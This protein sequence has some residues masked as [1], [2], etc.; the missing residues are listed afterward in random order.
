MTLD[1]Q[2]C[3]VRAQMKNNYCTVNSTP[4]RQADIQTDIYQINGPIQMKHFEITPQG[5][6]NESPH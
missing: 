2:E 3:M 6:E 1:Y 4:Q 5:K